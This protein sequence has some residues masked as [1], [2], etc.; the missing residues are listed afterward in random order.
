MLL[1]DLRR[2]YLQTRIVELSGPEIVHQLNDAFADLEE[3]AYQAYEAE[4]IARSRVHFFFFF[5]YRSE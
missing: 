5:C 1:S 3:T 4:N 2:D